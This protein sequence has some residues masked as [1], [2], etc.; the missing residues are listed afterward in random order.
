MKK[1]KINGKEFVI[2]KDNGLKS[3]RLKIN[4]EN[5]FKYGIPAVLWHKNGEKFEAWND[6]DIIDFLTKNDILTSDA[7]KT[8]EKNKKSKC[9]QCGAELQQPAGACYICSVCGE[10]EGCG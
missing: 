9:H 6:Q 8:W 1:I 2:K 5:P 3:S 7:K 10:S 4:G